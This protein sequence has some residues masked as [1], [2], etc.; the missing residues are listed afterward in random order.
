MAMSVRASSKTVVFV[1]GVVALLGVMLTCML[2][3][4]NQMK[5]MEAQ[6]EAVPDTVAADSI[7]LTTV[8]KSE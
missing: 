3:K 6:R 4:Y 7:E 5:R 8:A 1:A 2:C